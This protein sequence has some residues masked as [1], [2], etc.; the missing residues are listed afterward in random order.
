MND[1]M[2]KRK[3][4][5]IIPVYDPPLRWEDNCIEHILSLISLYPSYQFQLVF[6][7]DGSKR[8][9]FNKLRSILRKFK[10]SYKLYSL[11]KNYGKG[12]ALKTGVAKV[13]ADHYICVD[14][15]FPFGVIILGKLLRKLEETDFVIIDRGKHYYDH[16]PVIRSFITKVWRIF[17][18][19]L[20]HLQLNDTQGGLKGFNK[21]ISEHF[22]NCQTDSFLLDLEFIYMCKR[23]GVSIGVIQADL[24]PGIRFV[25]FPLRMYLRELVSF[26]RIIS[27]YIPQ[28]KESGTKKYLIMNADDFGMGKEVNEGVKR[29]VEAGIISSVSVMVNMPFF[30]DAVSFL[31]KHREISVGLHFNITQSVPIA[32]ENIHGTLVNADGTFFS[33][34]GLI[35]RLLLKKASYEDVRRELLAQYVKLSATGLSISHIDSHQHVHLLP[36]VFRLFHEFSQD[37]KIPGI[38]AQR[39]TLSHVFFIL[40]H[41]S[42]VKQC[43]ILI[44]FILNSII[45]KTPLVRTQHLYDLNWKQKTTIN[46]FLEYLKELPDGTTE[47]IC[48]PAYGTVPSSPKFLQQR[49]KTQNILLNKRVMSQLKHKHIQ[50]IGRLH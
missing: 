23:H 45:T 32:K 31:Q 48:H 9:S 2:R 42:T 13:Q 19:Y 26:V 47:I 25:N 27:R 6:V 16:L 50:L 18:K 49:S 28:E 44:G 43:V 30:E 34:Y 15:D 39:A 22:T 12:R 29:G 10:I 7:N 1:S 37:K 41:V 20:L 33:L 21:N 36:K 14:W 11:R 17:I 8:F 40:G 35:S 4:A 46:D 38:R 5:L 3:V 24:R